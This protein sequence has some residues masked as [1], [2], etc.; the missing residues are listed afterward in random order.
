MK[1]GGS[2]EGVARGSHPACRYQAP[3]LACID[4]SADAPILQ[5]QAHTLTNHTAANAPHLATR[6]LRMYSPRAPTWRQQHAVLLPQLLPQLL[7]CSPVRTATSTRSSSRFGGQQAA[8]QVD[9]A[10]HGGVALDEGDARLAQ[11]TC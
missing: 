7:L 11:S 9:P 8:A 5:L 4:S 6:P 10:E 3:R 2:Q 1:E